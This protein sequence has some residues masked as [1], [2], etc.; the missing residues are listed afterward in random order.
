[1]SNEDPVMDDSQNELCYEQ[2]EAMGAGETVTF[3]CSEVIAGR[4]V[5]VQLGYQG[6]LHLCEVEVYATS[7]YH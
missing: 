2:E 4:Y 3:P 6:Y 5:T 1:M 7:K